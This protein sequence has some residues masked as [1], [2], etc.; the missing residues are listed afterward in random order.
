M[1][2]YLCADESEYT[3]DCATTLKEA[4]QIV[5]AQGK[6]EV[7]MVEVDVNAETIRA[8]LG[9]HGGYAKNMGKSWRIE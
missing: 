8:L 9:N 7:R 4:K 5:A 1:K 2:F 6:G 3:F